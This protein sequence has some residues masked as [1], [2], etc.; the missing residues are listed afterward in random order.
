[1]AKPGPSCKLCK[2]T[3]SGISSF[4]TTKFTS[5]E[6]D[7]SAHAGCRFCGY[8]LKAVALWEPLQESQVL[9]F[10]QRAAEHRDRRLLPNAEPER[11]SIL[12]REKPDTSFFRSGA[13]WSVSAPKDEYKIEIY[14]PNGTF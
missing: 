14:C 8:I 1:M 4:T 3:D 12:S 9:K 5:R 6:L 7:N 10:E 2:W 13:T 11:T